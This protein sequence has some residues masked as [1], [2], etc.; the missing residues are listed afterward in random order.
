MVT[1]VDAFRAKDGKIFE[2]EAEA[3]GH[4]ATLAIAA[5]MER[6]RVGRGGEWCDDMFRD[7]M[8]GHAAELA[9]LL[10]KVAA[11]GRRPR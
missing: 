2:T 5:V 11:S 3:D 10:T 7:F 4:E 1:R 9:P 6:E 8:I